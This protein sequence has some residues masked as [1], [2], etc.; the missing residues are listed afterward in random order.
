MNHFILDFS[1]IKTVLGL[2]QYLKE[3]F[4]LPAY[5]GTY[6][7]ALWVCLTCGYDE[8]TT[9]ELRHLD[10]LQ[11]RLEKTTQTMLEVFLDLHDEDGVVILITEEDTICPE[12]CCTVDNDD[13]SGFLV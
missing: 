8:S 2:H 13:L 6:M 4:D 12:K 7:D 11:R 1:E 5:Y 10:T 3:V 9:I